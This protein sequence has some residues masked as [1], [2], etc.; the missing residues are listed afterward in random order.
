VR[1]PPLELA[2]HYF[3]PP[4][5]AALHAL[6][7]FGQRD[8]FFALWTLKESFIKALG[9]GLSMPLDRFAVRWSPPALLPY[10][11]FANTAGDWQ[12]TQSSPTDTCRLAVCVHAPTPPPIE[13][14]WASGDG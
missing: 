5:V 14:A 12:F 2:D 9:L 6:D 11:D 8:A 4:E 13:V 7:A 3:A 1:D 10:G